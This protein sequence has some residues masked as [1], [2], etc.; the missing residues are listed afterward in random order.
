M[1]V[2]LRPGPVR[3]LLRAL[4]VAGSVAAGLLVACDDDPLQGPGALIAR[5]DAP[6]SELGSAVLE[7]RGSGIRGFEAA[8][9]ARVFARD[10]G[11][12]P[13]RVVVA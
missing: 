3:P 8:G 5:V 10:V 9:D 7:V 12:G 2:R 6:S 1:T 11:D 13:W 4:V